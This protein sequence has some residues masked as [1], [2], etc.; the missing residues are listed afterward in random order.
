MTRNIQIVILCE[1]SQHESFARRFLK[2]Q[3][4]STRRI[5]VEKSSSGSA[6]Q[7]VRNRFPKEL[8]AYRAK[9][10]QVGQALIVLIDGDNKGVASRLAELASACKDEPVS[11]RQKDERVALFVPSWNIETWFAYLDGTTVDEGRDNYPRLPRERE[12]QR[13]VD[14]LDAMCQ[15]GQLRQ[16]VPD[17]LK[18][19]CDEYRERLK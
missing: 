7:F 17:S 8:A 18:M 15:Q 12:C 9:K 6:E 5:R 11:S 14:A 16:P 4:F 13:H 10:H 3:G 19:A 2:T 1:D